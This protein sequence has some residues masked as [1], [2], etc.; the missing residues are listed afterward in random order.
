MEA[1]AQTGAAEI[2]AVADP[3]EDAACEAQKVAPSARRVDSLDQILAAGVDGVVIA[4][5]NAV[6]AEQATRALERGVAVFCQKPLGRNAS[7]VRDVIAA[8]RRADRLR[9]R[10]PALDRGGR[11]PDP[12]PQGRPDHRGGQPRRVDGA[13]RLLRVSRAA[14][15]PRAS[16]HRHG[17]PERPGP[18]PGRCPLRPAFPALQEGRASERE[19]DRLPPAASRL[20][21]TR[22]RRRHPGPSSARSSRSRATCTAGVP[23]GRPPTP[24]GR[25]PRVTALEGKHRRQRPRAPGTLP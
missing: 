2:V 8:A 17:P 13:R 21:A 24:L 9:H 15:N 6:H 19:S 14:A 3:S 22:R 11:G 10:P 20:S 23:A 4:T 5:P 7:E 25:R 1:I 18:G 12:G 16:A